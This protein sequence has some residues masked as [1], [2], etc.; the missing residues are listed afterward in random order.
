MGRA[1]IY[2]VYDQTP[3]DYSTF[4]RKIKDLGDFRVLGGFEVGGSCQ[5]EGMFGS[6]VSMI[7]TGKGLQIFGCE[8]SVLPDFA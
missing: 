5:E 2:S 6:G 8:A 1:D 4:D 7:S 3:A